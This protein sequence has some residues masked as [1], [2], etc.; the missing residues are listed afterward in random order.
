MRLIAPQ[1]RNAVEAWIADQADE[2]KGKAIIASLPSL[3]T[4]VGWIWSPG[5]EILSKVHFPRIKTFDSSS[6]PDGF[7]GGKMPVL[8]A[9]DPAVISGKLASIKDE[10]EANDPAK[11]KAKIRE[12][13]KHGAQPKTDD[14]A[15][16]AAFQKGHAEGYTEGVQDATTSL[17]TAI[18]NSMSDAASALMRGKFKPPAQPHIAIHSSERTA[19]PKAASTAATCDL[20]RAQQRVVDSLGFWIS[21]GNSS[22]TRSQV[23][24]VSGYSVKSSGFEK[25]LSQLS[26]Q[27]V[28]TRPSGSLLALVDPKM[29]NGLDVQEARQKLLGVLGPAQRRV[30]D[31]FNGTAATKE[32]IADRSQYSV[33]SSGF[34]KTL[35]QLSSIGVVTRPAAGMVDLA[36]WVR[37]IL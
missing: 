20:S 28:I 30:L 34:E 25:T 7:A 33:T 17:R 4:G 13:Q 14:K 24:A 32:E 27:G 21:V 2:E 11:L 16:Q 15:L 18:G 36:D 5:A 37:E 3:P 29:A 6:A 19:A 12:L 31:A 9:I 8:A 22:P 26:T 23:A 10:A 1:D 35:S